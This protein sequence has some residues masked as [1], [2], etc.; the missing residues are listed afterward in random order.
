MRILHTSDWHIGRTF[1]GERVIDALDSVLSTLPGLVREHAVDA[2]LIPGDVFDSTTPRAE[3]LTL[4]ERVLGAIRAAGATVIV[5][6]GNHDSA[7]RLGFQSCWAE[8]AGI[9]IRTSLDRIG[10]PVVVEDADGPVRI[11]G[12][13]YLEPVFVRSRPGAD[14]VRSQEQAIE[15]AMGQIRAD[16]DAHPAR[17]IVLA[18][19][20]AA[21]V[22]E[23]AD[24]GDLERD[25]T[26]GGLDVVPLSMFDGIDYVALGHIHGRAEL[27]GSVRYSGAPLHYSFEEEGRARGAWLADLDADGLAG[28]RW[29]DYPVPRTV[30]RLRGELSDLLQNPEFAD[31]ET[32]WVAVTVTDPAR[33]QEPMRRLRTRFPGALVLEHRPPGVELRSDERRSRLAAAATDADIVDAF[34]QEVRSGMGLTGSERSL[35]AEAVDEARVEEAGR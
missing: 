4:F 11:Y 14:H 30:R 26:A 3:A 18:H 20:F 7:V 13:P 15:W 23:T 10:E 16:L 21:G 31:A 22:P 25:L 24:A 35:I 34:L 12:I 32:A 2:V 5:T 33:P 8:K 1:H 9:H 29:L 28:A 6:S 27:S 17:S 19:C